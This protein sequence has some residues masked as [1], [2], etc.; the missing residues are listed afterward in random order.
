MGELSYF[1]IFL[2]IGYGFGTYRERKHFKSIREREEEYAGREVSTLDSFAKD[3]PYKEVKF[4]SGN[5]VIS[6]DFFKKFVA[7]IR[8]IF[9]GNVSS[10]ESLVDR[11]RR[12]AVLR[13][14]SEAGDA[15][16]I[17]NTRIETSTL[18]GSA[19]K[20]KSVASIEAYAYGTALW[21]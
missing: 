8:N 18:G 7:G 16:M 5:A 4:V 14:Y 20:K 2:S 1:I 9:G 15:D 13:M 17:I 21:K 11:A 6:T 19:N 12:E 3:H 10:Y